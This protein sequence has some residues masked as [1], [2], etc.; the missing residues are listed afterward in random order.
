MVILS[1]YAYYK[2]PTVIDTIMPILAA[3][4]G[5]LVVASTPAGKNSFYQLYKLAQSLPDWWTYFKTVED[6]KHITPEA[7]EAER[8]R[9]SPEMFLQEFYCDFSRGISGAVFGMAL[10][11][12]RREG[13]IT[14]VNFNPGLLVHV[15]FD[16]GLSKGN[17]TAIIWFQILGD[18]H[19]I[20]IIDCYS[21]INQGLDFYANLLQERQ[22]KYGYKMGIYLAPHDLMVR[23]WGAGAVTR[24]EKA[25]QLDITFTVLDQALLEDQIENSLTH[26]SKVWIDET[27]CKALIDALENYHREWNE[28]HQVY[29]K[30]VHNWASNY[31][32]A[33]MG[34]F[35]GLHHCQTTRSA[36]D[37]DKIRNEALYGRNYGGSGFFRDALRDQGIK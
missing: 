15:S 6:T 28:Q 16:I 25:R 8:K 5:V 30:P 1:E 2:D 29:G 20:N 12:L 13:H 4:Q 22:H 18:N 3:N 37:Y 23:E 35:L 7:L 21:S 36:Q 17:S 31:S 24:Y 34:I 10:A 14:H 32:S 27:K 26:F 33:F 19:S 9:M 11:N